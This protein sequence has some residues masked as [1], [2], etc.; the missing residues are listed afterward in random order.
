[1]KKSKSVFA[2]ST[3]AMLLCASASAFAFSTTPIEHR[4]PGP[5]SLP[6]TAQGALTLTKNGKSLTCN[7][8]FVGTWNMMGPVTLSKVDFGT[9]PGCAGISTSA[10]AEAPLTGQV[11]NGIVTLNNVAVNITTDHG[12]FVCGPGTLA[13]KLQGATLMFTEGQSNLG[14]CTVSGNM[15]MQQITPLYL[16]N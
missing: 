5:V 3:L 9:N 14:D 6:G 15:S 10:S 4:G 1:M 12:K 13:A 16:S 2:V 8:V 11:K 7:T